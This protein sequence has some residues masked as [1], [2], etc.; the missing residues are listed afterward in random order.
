[1]PRANDFS[2]SF[3]CLAW[4]CCPGS[5]SS[6]WHV[7][8]APREWLRGSCG[9]PGD[10]G[11]ASQHRLYLPSPGSDRTQV[12]SQ[13]LT[14][15]CKKG[16]EM[17][18]SQVIQT[19][20]HWNKTLFNPLKEDEEQETG[21]RKWSPCIHFPINCRFGVGL[22]YSWIQGHSLL[23]VFHPGGVDSSLY[24]YTQ[25]HPP[26]IWLPWQISTFQLLVSFV[27]TADLCPHQPDTDQGIPHL[28][29]VL[30]WAYGV[31]WTP[32][33]LAIIAF[34]NI[35]APQLPDSDLSE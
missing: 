19:Q 33:W 30:Q 26:S 9:S 21:L 14:Q 29:A 1:M 31:G 32:P 4:A 34:P 8:G 3:N 35:F 17:T 7:V 11:A 10:E 22:S 28:T 6:W 15:M 5:S 13:G 16:K 12:S 25:M 20:I 24:T 2:F 18:D 23:W 27:L